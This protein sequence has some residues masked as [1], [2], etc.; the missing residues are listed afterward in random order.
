MSAP[1]SVLVVNFG[2]PELVSQ[3]LA[4]LA[5]HDDRAL[6]R[7]LIVVDNGFPGRG[8]SRRSV[9]AEGLPFPVRFAQNA[10]TSYASGVNRAAALA[11][12]DMLV[13]CNSDVEWLEHESVA[14]L[15][16]A[17]REPDV[18]IAGPQQVFP[19]G[20]WQRSFGPFPSLAEGLGSLVFAESVRNAMAAGRHRRA[21]PRGGPREVQYV[22]G[23]FMAVRRTCFEALGGFDERFGFYAE[24]MDFCARAARQGWRSRF[25]PA[26]RV[27]H[28]RGASSTAAAPQAYYERMLSARVAFVHRHSGPAAAAWYARVLRINSHERAAVYRP[29][30]WL[31]GTARWRQR[32]DVAVAVAKASGAIRA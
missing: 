3:L 18:G 11:G 30:A 24:D 28:V 31:A 19:D 14:P 29:L 17:I 9:T 2:T 12:G 4:S 10:G 25:V 22:D 15:V 6:V 8:D 1:L 7:E 32:L 16:D 21:G 5:S 23:A 20:S 26:A 13:V 27:L